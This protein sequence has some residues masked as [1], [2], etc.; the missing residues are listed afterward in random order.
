MKLSK[1]TYN[2][3]TDFQNIIENLLNYQN[4][5]NYEQDPFNGE[6]LAVVISKRFDENQSIEINGNEITYN[7][8]DYSYERVRPGE[9]DNEM[10]STR[11]YP[12]KGFLIVYTDGTSTQIITNRSSNDGTK[13]ILRKIN[14]CAKNLE[15]VP[16]RFDFSEDMF[17]WTIYKALRQEEIF[18]DE[19]SELVI[20]KIIGF[21]GA[22]EEL[23]E[24]IG[25]GS[26]IMNL[27]STLAFLFENETVSI[28]QPR[29][30]YNNNVIDLK[31]DIGGNV[32]VAFD[33]YTGDY[34]IAQEETRNA[35]VSLIAL[36]EIIPKFSAAYLTDK[37]EGVWSNQLKNDFFTN[38]GNEIQEKI[39]EKLNR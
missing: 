36:L 31:L 28:I 39:Q 14:N 27:L 29:I 9:D 26:T 24:V 17:I 6:D 37:Q 11:I 4:W 15:I 33:T 30:D 5:W 20:E 19:T 8:I 16:N 10:R 1:W 3:E 12:Q 32:E 7:Y 18:S 25:K 22:T 13:T 35:N 21:K 34:L 38:I 2:T 23:A